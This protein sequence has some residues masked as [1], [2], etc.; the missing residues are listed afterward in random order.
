[1]STKDIRT[2]DE[3][4]VKIKGKGRGPAGKRKKGSLPPSKPNEGILKRRQRPDRG[5]NFY[6]LAQL[7]VGS[8]WTD[9]GYRVTGG[10]VEVGNQLFPD[11][12]VVGDF[13]N[14]NGLFFAVPSGQWSTKFRK[15]VKGPTSERYEIFISAGATSGLL[16]DLDPDVWTSGGLVLTQSDLDAGLIVAHAPTGY[17]AGHLFETFTLLDGQPNIKI[18]GT[19]IYSDPAVPFSPI[20]KMDIFWPAAFGNLRGRA[21]T[22]TFGDRGDYGEVWLTLPRRFF[23][24]SDDPVAGGD[25]GQDP[26]PGQGFDATTLAAIAAWLDEVPGRGF[27]YD[28]GSTTWTG[29][30]AT[31]PPAGSTGQGIQFQ[32]TT[33]GSSL[34]NG[35]LIG[36]VR[37]ENSFYYFWTDGI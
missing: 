3:I 8:S 37:K 18:T 20:P 27:F 21:A 24:N 16:D 32:P 30:G 1:M 10:V 15:V 28:F 35:A 31:F 9:N 26:A 5:I 23:I 12:L 4:I 2:P 33:G 13:D 36:I 7:K 19:P 6:D 25:A 17:A 29:P 14:R 34:I 22:G 11:A